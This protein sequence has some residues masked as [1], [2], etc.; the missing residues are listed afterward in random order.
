MILDDIERQLFEKYEIDIGRDQFVRAV[1]GAELGRFQHSPIAR[2]KKTKPKA[3]EEREVEFLQR[4]VE[5]REEHLRS[6]LEF[7]SRS[8]HRQIVI[9]LDNTDQRNDRDQE[10]AFLIAEEMSEQWGALVFLPLRPE[11]FHASRQRGALTGYH[12]RAFTVSPPRLDHI[13]QKR[14]AFGLRIARGEYPIPNLS[15]GVTVKLE[16][17]QTLIECFLQSLKRSE[18]LIECIDNIASGNVRTALDLVKD[19]FGSGHVDTQKIIEKYRYDDYVVP[20]HEFLRAVIYGDN[21]FYNPGRAVL[22]SETCSTLARSI[23]GS[24]SFYRACLA[25]FTPRERGRQRGGL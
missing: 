10:D 3:Y 4:F 20:L 23:R 2:L 18:E 14:L 19:F 12:T 17:L 11:T 6:S 25:L 9:F 24:I 8:T 1:Y 13:L 5:N 7:I 21:E 22:L 15:A 16:G